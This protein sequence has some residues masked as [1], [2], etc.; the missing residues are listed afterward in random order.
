MSIASEFV[1]NFTNETATVVKIKKERSAI[2]KINTSGSSELGS[3][4]LFF[5]NYV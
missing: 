4:V 5:Q 1:S 2:R 3:E